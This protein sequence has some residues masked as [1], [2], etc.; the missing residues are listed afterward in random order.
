MSPRS[1]TDSYPAFAHIGLRENPG[2]NLNQV[3]CPNR[4]SNPDH[5]VS[6]PDALTVTPQVSTG[7]TKW[8]R[9]KN[10]DILQEL[11]LSSI[12]DYIS[13]Y[14]LNW[15]EHVSRMVSSRI[16]KAIMKYRPNGKRRHGQWRDFPGEGSAR[17]SDHLRK[18]H[19]H[20][21]SVKK[22]VSKTSGNSSSH[23][24]PNM[25]PNSRHSSYYLTALQ[26]PLT[27][28][29][30]IIHRSRIYQPP[31]KEVQWVEICWLFNDAV[32]TTRLFRVYEIGDS[33]IVFGEMRLR[34]P[35]GKPRKKPKQVISPS[36]DRTRARAQLQTA[37][38]AP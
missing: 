38:Q 20:I 32:S 31:Q 22:K 29:S 11:N 21:Q 26:N 27:K 37:R 25:L 34:I 24:D 3:T 1:S 5:L 30:F 4:E 14:Q 23:R 35:R 15:K 17:R 13:R 33:E 10:E 6:R 36:G 8:D 12:L 9:R 28:N 2:K 18:K 7:Y 19:E 16:P